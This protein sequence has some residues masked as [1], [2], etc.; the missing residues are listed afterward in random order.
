MDHRI[1]LV[2]PN[3][4]G[5]STMIKILTGQEDL[6]EGYYQKHPKLRISTFTQHHMDQL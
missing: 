1:A 2:G 3:G 6:V 5:K 4:C